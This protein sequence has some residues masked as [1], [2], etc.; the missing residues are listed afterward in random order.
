MGSRL[1]FLKV[2]QSRLCVV[3]L[4]E[5]LLSELSREE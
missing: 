1:G 3:L 5:C 2:F 4:K